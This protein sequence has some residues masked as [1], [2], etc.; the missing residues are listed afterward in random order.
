MYS[1]P[2]NYFF[3]LCSY[4]VFLDQVFK[5][6]VLF[7]SDKVP[8]LKNEPMSLELHMA[9]ERARAAGLTPSEREWRK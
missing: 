4:V 8:H 2:H 3:I 1:R 7:Q 6:W 9:D 5:A